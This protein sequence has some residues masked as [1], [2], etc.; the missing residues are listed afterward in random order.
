[1]ESD[2]NCL[3]VLNGENVFGQ[4]GSTTKKLK[5]KDWG[6]Q[7]LHWMEARAKRKGYAAYKGQFVKVV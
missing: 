4:E 5:L 1:L 2:K 7:G 6:S 3:V